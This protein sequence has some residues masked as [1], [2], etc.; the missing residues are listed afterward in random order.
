MALLT[1][2]ETQVADLL[3]DPAN[4]VWKTPQLDRYINEARRQVVRDSG[5]LRQLQTAYLTP[6]QEVYTFGQVTGASISAGG[7]GYTNPSIGF[8]GG[9]GGSG[10][11]ATVT[12]SGGAVNA[13]TFS[14]FGSG[15]T[16]APSASVT[17][18]GAG[19]GAQIVVG[20]VN[21]NTYDVLGISVVWGNERYAL[22]W[23]PFSAFSARLRTWLS[24]AYQRQPVMWAVYGNTQFYVGPPPD[25]PYQFELDTVVLPVDLAGSAVDPIPPIMQ[26]PIK[27]YAA[28]LAKFNQQAY[29]E[30]EMLKQ[31]YQRTVLECDAAY[32]R[33][34]PNPYEV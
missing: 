33:R 7:T 31:A 19:S 18:T 17:D 27:F 2:Y 21:V 10:V 32:T 28:Y 8:S 30:A 12:Q 11:A 13:I 22:L 24:S 3:H 20:V 9:G 14:S 23:Q 15:Y 4:V 5:C 25:Q 16:T 34:I 6:G 29:G 1:D 26:D